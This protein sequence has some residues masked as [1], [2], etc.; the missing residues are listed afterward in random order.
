MMQPQRTTRSRAAA[1]KTT[2]VHDENS[3]QPTARAGVKAKAALGDSAIPTKVTAVKKTAAVQ[4]A[5][6]R[7]NA[8]G[9][10]GPNQAIKRQQAKQ[11]KAAAAQAAQAATEA[12]AP[13]KDEKAQ[14]A[15][16]PLRVVAQ[17]RPA[18]APAKD[19]PAKVE[20]SVAEPEQRTKTAA[21]RRTTKPNSSA[22]SAATEQEAKKE[23][24]AKPSNAVVPK[25]VIDDA[26]DGVPAGKKAKIVERSW[27]DMDADEAEDPMMVAEYVPEIF[28]HLKKLEIGTM[29]NANYMEQ[30]QELHWTMRGILVDWLIEVHNKFR[31]LP[32]T[33]YLAINIIDRFLS[34]RVVS[35]TKLQLVGI[36][37]LFIASKYEEV[38][39]P[40][41][42]NFIYMGDGGV[43]EDDLLRAERYVLQVLDFDLQYPGPMSFLRRISKADN[44]EVETRTVA[45]FLMEISLVDHR[46][47]SIRPSMTAS[48]AMLVARKV[49]NRGDWDKNFVHYSGYTEEELDRPVRLIQSYLG[50]QRKHEAL[51]KKYSGRKFAKASTVVQE[52]FEKN[53]IPFDELSDEE[54]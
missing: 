28:E 50:R 22:S 32:E 35:I 25:H 5:A 31:L 51:I 4:P 19:V 48:A 11:E 9:E 7:R 42:A 41:V 29:P 16:R 53:A 24:L 43:V 3:A 49:L 20:P 8:L 38:I 27:R 45:K 26:P 12:P 37:A 46:F 15:K 14:P 47:L 44:Y 36:A 21:V 6:A 2:G 34:A 23:N 30:Q 1:L 10:R 39:P 54:L 13:V 52:W 40:T 18:L 33:L 17:K